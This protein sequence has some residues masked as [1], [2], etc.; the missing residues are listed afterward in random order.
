MTMLDND[1][2]PDEV[3][4]PFQSPTFTWEEGGEDLGWDNFQEEEFSSGLRMPG[5]DKYVKFGWS[6]GYNEV[7]DSKNKPTEEMLRGLSIPLANANSQLQE[8]LE[9][10][11]EDG[12]GRIVTVKHS[13]T[14]R[15]YFLFT[16]GVYKMYPLMVGLPAMR[17]I[18]PFEC[19]RADGPLPEASNI[20]G[21]VSAR[22][23]Y[24]KWKENWY[25]LTNFC[26][27]LFV[28]DVL[29]DYGYVDLD[30]KPI[31]LC[32]EGQSYGQNEFYDNVLKKHMQM[33][34]MAVKQ[35]KYRFA[36]PYD[37]GLVMRHN[38]V[39]IDHGTEEGKKSKA[40]EIVSQLP[41]KITPEYIDS[42]YIGPERSRI[43]MQLCHSRKLIAGRPTVVPGGI[44]IDWA[45][46][47]VEF[48][49]ANQR[50]YN[51]VSDAFPRGELKQGKKNPINTSQRLSKMLNKQA[52]SE[53]ASQGVQPQLEEE[54]Q[55]AINLLTKNGFA[56]KAAGL[57]VV[58]DSYQDGKSTEDDI[59]GALALV[60]AE[61]DEILAK[62]RQ[63][64]KRPTSK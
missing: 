59:Q 56:Q 38:P 1:V 43:L 47:T 29:W 11:V 16:D 8:I 40:H 28:V 5:D 52:L 55:A 4:L 24:V 53:G 63:G 48:C 39:R 32:F 26:T 12:L 21:V 54:V 46:K 25:S 50:E 62:G 19:Y 64:F 41:E 10:L 17:E 6:H 37:F 27:C 30:N 57:Q 18:V 33:V 60:Q 45:R 34:A 23:T 20:L 51:P 31:P 15:D 7:L 2:W 22:K 36:R 13:D 61:R 42:M 58:L 14:T 9:K 35:E 44:A 49:V 3:D